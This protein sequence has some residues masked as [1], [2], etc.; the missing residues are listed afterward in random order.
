[1]G[2]MKNK[3]E[4]VSHRRLATVAL[5]ALVESALET[6][7]FR[8][9][10]VAVESQNSPTDYPLRQLHLDNEQTRFLPLD[11]DSTWL[12]TSF[13]SVPTTD[14]SAGHAL[15][16]VFTNGIPSIVKIIQIAEPGP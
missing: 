7:I 2:E 1:M 6:L 8:T 11:P 14:F 12:D 15:V 16:T 3:E 5:A 13:T 9:Q 4:S 10:G